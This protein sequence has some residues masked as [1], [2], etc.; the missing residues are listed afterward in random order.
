MKPGVGHEGEQLPGSGFA[1]Q[2]T[3]PAPDQHGRERHR[4]GGAREAVAGG[5][6]A[7]LVGAA[8]RRWIPAAQE[9]WIPVPRPAAVGAHANVLAQ[10]LQVGGPG[11][12][13]VVGRHRVGDLLEGGEPVRVPGHEVVDALHALHLDPG[14]HV[15]QYQR[16]G[17]GVS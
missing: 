6:G 11:P 15:D 12:V 14:R 16:I 3:D 10:S 17:D 13:R 2:V 1:Q 7:G 8:V 9:A 5:E 4:P